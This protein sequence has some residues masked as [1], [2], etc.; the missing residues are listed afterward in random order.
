[1][2]CEGCNIKG[3]RSKSV[4]NFRNHF[5]FCENSEERR[6]PPNPLPDIKN[7]NK[8]SAVL[9]CSNEITDEQAE[10]PDE[11]TINV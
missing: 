5:D 6:Q 2:I 8:A 4:P 1:M 7:P 9:Q 3:N 10:E 11:V